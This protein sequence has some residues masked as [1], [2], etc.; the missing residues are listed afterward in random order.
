M[1]NQ[2]SDKLVELALILSQ[3]ND[4]EEILRLVA[5]KAAGLMRADMALIMMINSQTRETVK[6]IYTGGMIAGYVCNV[7]F[8]FP[9]R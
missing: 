4:Y 3:Q 7:K 9:C 1:E 6:T 8:A 5:Q 2:K